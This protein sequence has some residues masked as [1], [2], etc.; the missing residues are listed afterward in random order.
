MT[1]EMTTELT[2]RLPVLLRKGEERCDYERAI[3]TIRVRMDGAARPKRIFVLVTAA[4]ALKGLVRKLSMSCCSDSY[5][6]YT[7]ERTTKS[8]SAW[9]RAF[10]Q[11]RDRNSGSP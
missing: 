8:L 3:L 6:W 1:T 7:L 9:K 5:L 10:S 4:G 2:P 11:S